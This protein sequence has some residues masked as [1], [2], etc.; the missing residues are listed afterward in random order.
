MSWRRGSRGARSMLNSDL[1]L[2]EK[3]V[4]RLEM[5]YFD[6]T[7]SLHER[8]VFQP[9]IYPAAERLLVATGRRRIVDVGCGI[10]KKLAECSAAEKM[11]IDFGSNIAHCRTTYPD[12]ARWLELDLGEAISPA[13]AAEIGDTDVIICSDVVEHLADPRPLLA[14]L[15]QCFDQGAL[16]LTSTP[17]RILV[18]GADHLGPPPNPAHVREWSTAEYGA[19][20]NAN[21]LPALYLGLT[22]NNDRDKLLRTIVSVHEP[23]LQ[24]AF[25]PTHVRPLAILSC[26]NE[27]DVLEQVIDNWITQGCDLYLIDN[28]STDRSWDIVQ[29][30]AQ[31]YGRHV[32][33]ERFPVERPERSAWLHILARK[34]EVAFCHQ[35]RWIIHTDADEIRDS[36]FY[37]FSLAD[38]LH[39]VEIAGWNRVDFTLLNHRPVDDVAWV[40]GTIGSALPH[41]EYGTKPGH[42]LQK[43]AWLQGKEKVRLVPSGGHLAEFQDARDCPYRFPLHHYP[44]RSANHARRKVHQE[45]YGRWS[46]AELDAGMHHHYADLLQQETIVWDASTLHQ[47][48][49]DFWP[50]HGFHILVGV[51]R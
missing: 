23:R 37:P 47:V 11:G 6:D 10:G 30:A 14:F 33:T 12:A 41:F 21:G 13:V 28:W 49:V 15:R 7:L 25:V 24:K 4:S 42:F 2:P 27:E 51:P 1:F 9:E 35:G 17:D 43:K 20:L 34:E 36:P 19:L 3:Y 46:T 40:P 38:A 22:Y 32:M 5:D 44:L 31:R 8:V 29:A 45:R 16:V 18:R 26:Y 48:D 50:Q 39:M